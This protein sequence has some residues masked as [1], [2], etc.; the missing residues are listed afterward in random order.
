VL[1]W[2]LKRFLYRPVLEVIDRRRRG[3]EE[4]KERV[5]ATRRDTEALQERVRQQLAASERDRQAK[6][7]ELFQEIEEKRGGMMAELESTLDLER[8]KA[9]SAEQQR[10]QELQRRLEDLALEQGARFA[11]RLVQGL[12]GPELE[13]RLAELLIEELEGMPEAQRRTIQATIPLSE[14]PVLEA[15]SAYPL[16]PALRDR[17]ARALHQALG[18]ELPVRFTEEPELRAGL[19]VNIG[20]WVLHANL[21]DELRFFVEAARE[22]D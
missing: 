2:I 3:I 10:R 1:A 5:Q 4:E 6:L 15:S 21:K 11:A 16:S 17:I 20:Y 12:A 7:D 19:R 8:R 18:E 14:H 13:A 22:R 9:A